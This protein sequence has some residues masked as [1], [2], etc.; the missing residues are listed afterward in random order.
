MPCACTIPVPNYPTN[1]EW[2][3]I[4]WKLLHGLANKY[5][6]VISPLFLKEQELFWQKLFHETLHIL[7][8]KECR[9]HYKTYLDNNNPSILKTLSPQEQIHW[10]Q[11]FFFTLHNEINVRNNKPLFEFDALHDLYKNVS[12]RFTI[13][14]YEKLL[15][16][17]FQYNE[18]SL[19]SWLNWIKHF[20]SLMGIY[21]LQ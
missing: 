8:C 10:V 18:V 2:G 16:I 11:M 3:P 14:H 5:G 20:R 9:E 19:L 17:V 6:K 7:P 1:C 12:F 4:L 13:K 15:K 21:G